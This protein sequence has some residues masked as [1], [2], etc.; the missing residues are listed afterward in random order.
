MRS[1]AKFL[2]KLETQKCDVLSEVAR[3]SSTQL[4][5]RPQPGDWSALDV[6][7]HLVKVEESL[8]RT[9]RRHLPDGVAISARDRVGALLI[10]S[11]MLSP[12]RVKVPASASMVLPAATMDL[13]AIVASW[14]SVRDQMANLLESLQ[15]A[16]FRM[17]VFQHPVS[18]WM[19][20]TD[21]LRFISAHLQHHRYQL[22]RL[23]LAARAN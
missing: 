15:P 4:R 21:T 23:K 2:R 8:L 1:S 7:D 6:L 10:T 22:N 12:M 3:L 13:P 19:T 5:F 20:M 14:S 11:V 9:V 18:G 17:G 16:Q